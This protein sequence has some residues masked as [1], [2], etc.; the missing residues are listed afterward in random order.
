VVQLE[1][2]LTGQRLELTKVEGKI[3][4]LVQPPGPVSG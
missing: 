3:A 2:E 1:A 4:A